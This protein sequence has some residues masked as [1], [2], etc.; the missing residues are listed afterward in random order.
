MYVV[1]GVL[2][3]VFALIESRFAKEPICPPRLFK[4]KNA[5]FTFIGNFLM[6]I[7]YFSFL[8]YL[9]SF[10][11]LVRGDSALVSGVELIPLV[12]VVNIV[13]IASVQFTSRWGNWCE[14]GCLFISYC[15]LGF[16]LCFLLSV[17]FC[18]P[19]RLD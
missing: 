2:I 7:A 13:S 9:P 8:F 11:Q 5:L 15:L 6:G 12:L 4:N 19:C 3:G 1:G 17:H 14:F 18:L 16:I 10:F